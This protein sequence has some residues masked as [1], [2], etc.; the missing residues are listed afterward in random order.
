MKKIIIWLC[1]FTVSQI[2]HGIEITVDNNND[3][4]SLICCEFGNCICNSF[5]NALSNIQNNTVI[6]IISPSVSLH[7]DMKIWNINNITIIS[8]DGTNIMCNNVGNVYFGLCSDVTVTGITWDQCGDINN[9]TFS[10]IY[11]AD[12]TSNI[13]IIDCTFQHFKTCNPIRISSKEG[14][15]NVINSK[16]MFNAVSN[17]SVCS[18]YYTLDISSSASI[19]IIIDN[20][21]FSHNGYSTE[22]SADYNSTL[23]IYVSFNQ[24]QQTQPI[25]IKN[26]RFNCNG[27]RAI[28]VISEGW[29]PKVIFD[30]INISDNRFGVYTLVD[31]ELSI[32]SSYF[33]LNENRALYVST[34]NNVNIELFNTTFVNNSATTNG[35]GTALN[36][37]I[38][39]DSAVNISLCNFYDNIGGNSIVDISTYIPVYH[40][41]A[42]GNVLINSTNF[43]NN[44]IGSAL[45]AVQCILNF[46]STTV[47]QGNSAKSG[48][49]LYIGERSQISVDDGST[50]QFINN[51]ASLRGGAMYIDLTNCYDHGIVFTNFTRYD[52]ISFINNSAKLSGNSIYFNIP[53]SCD[54]IRDYTNNNSAA[55]VPYKFNY[56][57]SHNI[58]DFQITASPYEIKLCSTSIC[59]FTNI[60]NNSNNVYMIEDDI[61]LGQSVY[62]STAM[63]GYFNASAEPT[64]FRVIC[65]NCKPKFKLLNNQLLVQNGSR[66]RINI[67]S[68][69]AN[70]DV[71]NGTNIVLNMIPSLLPPEYRQLTATLSLTL[72]SCNNGFLFSEQSQQC[73]CYNK[74]DY[75]QCDEDSASIKL[76][77]WFGLFHK[78]HTLSVCHN[79]YCNF[80]TENLRQFIRNGFYNLPKEKDDQCNSHRTGVACGQ[81]SE[82]YTLAYNSPD[83]ISV[84]KCSPGMTVLVIILTILYWIVIIAM[85]F[86]VAYFLNIQQISPGYLYSMTFF[87]SIVDILLVTNLHLT[88][89]VFYTATILSS[90]AKLNPQFLGRLC[91]VENLDAIDQQFIHYCHV[92]FVSII[93]AVIYIMIKCNN[94]ALFYVNRCTVQVTCFVLLFS[95]TSLTSASLLL[96]RAVKFDDIDGLYTYLSPHLKYF[97]NRHAAYA[98]VALLCVLLVTI[99]FPLLLVMEPLF[100]QAFNYQ[101][102][103]NAWKKAELQIKNTTEKHIWLLRIKQLL[104]QLQD[105]YKDQYRWFAAYYLICRLVI[106]LITYF[107]NDDYNYMIYYLQTACVV[108][109]MTH[110]WIQPYKNDLINKLDTAILLIMLLVVNV[111]TFSFPTSVIEGVAITLIFVPLI[112][113]F[114]FS[115]RK[116]LVAMMRKNLLTGDGDSNLCSSSTPG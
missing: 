97:I 3:N 94:R 104:D 11:F 47:F 17:A 52:S 107:A 7:A 88:D 39:S 29:R 59:N 63:Y 112:L 2:V 49:T 10:A 73:E 19:D 92:V 55:Y 84:D 66:N 82:G 32:I 100:V 37:F 8:N 14:S 71:E 31:G 27:I 108:I 79:D 75:L 72:S 40:P 78:K 51:T 81:C 96:L 62:F 42:F 83:C 67:L 90:L 1:L 9:P 65:V 91:F 115:V 43:M 6:N 33:T 38:S 22:G 70:A 46:H 109:T 50:V 61:M 41:F 35:F 34:L 89:G 13:S 45:R 77:Y 80:F 64:N 68:V 98:S 15:I 12:T 28:D 21:S 25:L 85:L 101:F 69:D 113:L 87:Y 114:G 93:L 44:K 23:S 57:Q 110:I 111:S 30:N 48:A 53:S 116:Y 26:S 20:S 86:G 54:V 99:G 56:T 36:V 95:Y 102:S 76:G 105:C 24:Y 18:S 4:G 106:M 103:K 16:F 74:D 58:D 5:Y 60:A